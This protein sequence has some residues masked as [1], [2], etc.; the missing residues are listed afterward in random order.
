MTDTGKRPRIAV[1]FGG[2]SAEHEVSLMSAA[3]VIANIDGAE[4]DVLP[5][6]VT[7]DGRWLASKSENGQL[8]TPETGTELCLIPGG[9]G[10]MLALDADG[11]GREIAPIDLVFPV[12][13][14]LPGEDGSVQGFAEVA[15]VALVG[16]GIT[17]SVSAIDKDVCKRLLREAGIATARASVILPGNAPKFADLAAELGVPL[18]IKPARQ[19][20]S[21]GVSK[22]TGESGYAAALAHGFRYDDK[23]LAE[24]F[25]IGREI[26]L[27]VLENPDGTLSVSRPGEIAS[28]ESH[29]FYSYEAK[30]VDADGTVLT[31][32]AD[33][34]GDVEERMRDI[35]A[36]AFRAL[37]CD[38]MAR[39][40]FF[41]KADGTVLVN[42]VN[43]I[44]GFTD[45]SMYSRAMAASGISY[46]QIIERLV[47]HGL[48]RE[49]RHA[50][51]AAGAET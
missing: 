22:V 9:R 40:D 33:I 13:H 20:S 7:R 15:G 48:A 11:T 5:V 25:V 8:A 39:V 1:L 51:R 26:E 12:L 21:V 47:A 32:P 30:Y 43:T 46:P 23:L 45:I 14:G 6:Y 27:G 50:R 49:G 18:F 38:G 41:F 4:L 3:N 37:G 44:P 42:E 36:T 34:P 19:G 10:R 24:E 31:A 2:R 29:S 17:G 35:A 28:A 16:C